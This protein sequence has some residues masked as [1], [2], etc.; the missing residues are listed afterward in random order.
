MLVGFGEDDAA[1]AGISGEEAGAG[2]GPLVSE[3]EATDGDAELFLEGVLVLGGA[4]PV[5]DGEA[6]MD[7]GFVRIG[8]GEEGF[9]LGFAGDADH[10]GV[11]EGGGAF[12]EA[13]LDFVQNGGGFGHEIGVGDKFFF[14][15]SFVAA[16]DGDAAFFE[17][18]GA[19]FD[20]DGHALFDPFPVPG[21]AGEVAP[22]DLDA[23]GFAAGGQGA[24]F[25]AEGIAGVQDGLF[26]IFFRGDGE[27]DNLVGGDAGRQDEAIVIAVGHDEGADEAGADAPGGGPG[28]LAR[29][30]AAGELDV[31]G[32]GEVLAEEVAG[33][34]LDGFAVLHHGLD[35]QGAFRAG[36]AF[37]LG[38]F[39]GDDGE[40]EVVAGEGFVDAEHLLGF[41]EGFLT[42]FVGGVAF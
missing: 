20:A 19:D 33:A 35:A 12:E 9:E 16:A 8:G 25:L 21:A 22:V 1:G 30:A 31:G 41:R 10:V 34:R 36:E 7:F 24:E 26:A 27:D 42:G 28:E 6:A 4:G 15:Q 5:D 39:T 18:A 2:L 3:G 11:A 23:E 14:F 17:V 29:A 37:A 13:G 40:C 38:F 32:F